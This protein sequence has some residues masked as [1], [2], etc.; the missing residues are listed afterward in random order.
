MTIA[1]HGVVKRF[2]AGTPDERVAIDAVTLRL[3]D[4][5]FAVVV[6]SNGAG[7]S[8]LLNLVAGTVRP[9]AGRIEVDGV[10]VTRWPT[11][12]RADR[13]ARVMQDPMVGTLP[14]L[15]VE[16][17][18]AL[19]EMR[20]RGRG[21]G[22]ALTRS[23]RERYREALAG[24]GLGLEQRL[25]AR[26]GTLSG[27]QRQVVS[28]AMAVLVAPRVLLLDEHTAALDPRTAALVQEATLR[29]VAEHRLTTL[30]VTHD[31]RLALATGD[32]LLM[33]HAGRVVLDARGDERAALTVDGLVQRFR[34]ADDRLLLA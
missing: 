12:R 17:N 27:G 24:F 19:A 25:G 18:L 2:H 33:M 16:E 20:G 9:D 10:D 13:I 5:E 29:A 11:H 21:F 7:K 3:D 4:G 23:R 8:T 34:L 15:T 30:M 28:L 1:L 14:T 22:A 26:V 32:R 31:M 6:G